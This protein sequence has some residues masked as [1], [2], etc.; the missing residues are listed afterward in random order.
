MASYFLL[1]ALV[2]V[3]GAVAAGHCDDMVVGRDGR[4]GYGCASL[5]LSVGAIRGN[6]WDDGEEFLMVP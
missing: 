5:N 2:Q 4:G 3:Q 6:V 1:T